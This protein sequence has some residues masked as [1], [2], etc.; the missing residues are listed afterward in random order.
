MTDGH[1]DDG[2]SHG[3]S[4]RGKMHK[5]EHGKFH[6]NIRGE[7]KYNEGGQRVELVA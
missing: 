7:K 6:L 5:L 1:K 3:N 2:V 4:L